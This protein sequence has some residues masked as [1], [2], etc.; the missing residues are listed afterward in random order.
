MWNE[1]FRAGYNYIKEVE[2]REK[3]N[4]IKQSLLGVAA[5]AVGIISVPVLE[6]DVTGA[7]LMGIIGLGLIL[8]TEVFVG[9]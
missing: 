8:S 6:G 4:R 9:Q 1:D 5:I 2:R 3:I 7:I